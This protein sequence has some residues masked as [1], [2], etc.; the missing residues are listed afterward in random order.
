MIWAV[1]ATADSDIKLT[2]GA[3]QG[4]GW[5]MFTMRLIVL[6]VW[7]HSAW[8]WNAAPITYHWDGAVHE[9]SLRWE[10]IEVALHVVAKNASLTDAAGRG[11][12]FAEERV[13]VVCGTGNL[14]V[15]RRFVQV[16]RL[17]NWEMGV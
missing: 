4:W 8:R 6:R 10:R 7:Y 5:A 16:M 13:L 3:R 15:C 2:R 1:A 12:S 14:W 11:G 17:E 9:A